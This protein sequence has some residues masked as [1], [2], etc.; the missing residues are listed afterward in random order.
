MAYTIRV[1]GDEHLDKLKAC[2]DRCDGAY[3]VCREEATRPHFHA[4]VYPAATKGDK[5]VRNIFTNGLKGLERTDKSVKV[6]DKP[7]GM[8]RYICKGPHEKT[9]KHDPPNIVLRYGA[10]YTDEYIKQ[11]WLAFWA[12][13]AELKAAKGRRLSFVEQVEELMRDL[14][15]AFTMPNIVK[16]CAHITVKTR[17]MFN[18]YQ[19]EGYAKM[20]AAR[21][22]RN[23][24]RQMIADMVARMPQI[25]SDDHVQSDI[26]PFDP[27][28]PEDARQS[29]DDE[30]GPYEEE[31]EG[32]T[33]EVGAELI[34]QPHPLVQPELPAVHCDR[35]CGVRAVSELHERHV[36]PSCEQFRVQFAV[37]PVQDQLLRDKVLVKNRSVRTNRRKRDVPQAVLGQGLQQ[38]DNPQP[39]RHEGAVQPPHCGVEAGPSSRDEVHP[40][41]ADTAELH[42]IGDVQLHTSVQEVHRYW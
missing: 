9:H 33:Q 11:Q 40:Q 23:A 38:P 5:A 15:M 29:Q 8:E 7:E 28:E 26:D 37:R 31:G 25:I 42:G 18:T 14:N 24:Y 39:E 27:L 3:L 30:E 16:S 35:E 41:S 4:I 13:N 36:E 1:T 22:N 34:E 2:L 19:I 10:K 32:S 20:V 12:Q 6:A 21:N 17:N